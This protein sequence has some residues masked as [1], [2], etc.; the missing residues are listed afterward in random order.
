MVLSAVIPLAMHPEAKT[1][2]VIGM[3]SGLTSHVLLNSERL[4]RVDTIEIEEAM[5][6]GRCCLRLPLTR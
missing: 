6:E 2:A 4:D 3:G 1:A 5:I